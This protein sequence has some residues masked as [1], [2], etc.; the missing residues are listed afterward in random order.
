MSICKR[1]QALGQGASLLLLAALAGCG[2][3]S[4]GGE[5]QEGA[6]LE[7]PTGIS[8]TVVDSS[9]GGALLVGSMRVA[10]DVILP[11]GTGN[12]QE[13]QEVPSE[14]P[15]AIVHHIAKDS[16]VV[17]VRAEAE[18]YAPT[19]GRFS[20][21]KGQQ[22]EARIAL[23]PTGAAPARPSDPPVEVGPVAIERPTPGSGTRSGTARR[24]AGSP[25]QPTAGGTPITSTAVPAAA[26]RLVTVETTP[27]GARIRLRNRQDGKV[28]ERVT[29]GVLRVPPG[30]YS[31]E[32]EL[33]GYMPDRSRERDLNL[34]VAASEKISR[35]LSPA[36][37]QEALAQAD[38]AYQA[39]R[40]AEAV[41][42]YTSV[43]RPEQLD[44][45]LGESYAQSRFRLA[46]CAQRVREY[47]DAMKAYV[48]VLAVAPG[49]WT[50][51]YQLGR[52][53][54]DIGEYSKGRVHLRELE[55][56]F[57][58][59]V[60]PAKKSTVQALARY[61]SAGCQVREFT[62]KDHPDRY[63]DLK[64]SALA[65]L[66]E[67]IAAGERLVRRGN[68]PS[69]LTSQLNSAIADAKAKRDELTSS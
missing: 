10:H 31:W 60:P 42:L 28:Y 51:K 20:A 40:C 16:L 12:G 35:V 8:L 38:N 13:T 6:P 21:P 43:R 39:G 53:H 34:T 33:D 50:A 30:I 57:L 69:E 26:S 68:V 24:R 37:G 58:G 29:N 14:R 5:T 7:P 47:D 63:E 19:S 48:E 59:K 64:V 67:F 25:D 9:T 41:R 61:A 11:L 55:G 27:A 49:Q 54:C 36:D 62:T 18:G 44:G 22:V 3:D 15:Y 65:A 56:S 45:A 23:Q 17:E 2:G 52:L 46:Q 1:G 4:G 32:L 66:E